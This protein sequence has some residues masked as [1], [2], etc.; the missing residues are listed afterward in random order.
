LGEALKEAE[1]KLLGIGH[2]EAGYV[3][4][5]HWNI[6][7]QIAEVIRFHESPQRAPE[8]QNVAAI[9]NLAARIAELQ[10]HGEE[11]A[12]GLFHSSNESLEILGLSCQDALRLYTDILAAATED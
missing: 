9:V 10:I 6:P 8:Q 2:P 12:E 1:E 3:L 11:A 4:A 5:T 7:E